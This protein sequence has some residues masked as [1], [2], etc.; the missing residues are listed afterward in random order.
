MGSPR[1]SPAKLRLY[2]E[3][4]VRG[5]PIR[6]AAEKSGMSPSW[7]LNHAHST[8][9]DHEFRRDYLEP[10]RERLK[11]DVAERVTR[12]WIESQYLK[13]ASEDPDRKVKILALKELSKIGDLDAPIRIESP[14]PLVIIQPKTDGQ[15]D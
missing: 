5:L 12:E 15:G 10:E 7:C 9:K 14:S 1:V 2:A 11:N 13:I 8:Y 6:E 3:L 4:L